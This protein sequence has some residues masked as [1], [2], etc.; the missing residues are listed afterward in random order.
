[1]SDIV[2]IIITFLLFLCSMLI[3]WN[4]YKNEKNTKAIRYKDD[5]SGFEIAEKILENNGLDNLYI[6]ETRS[7]LEERY[8]TRRNVI[9]LLPSRFHGLSMADG[10]NA[11]FLA[12]HAIFDR[13]NLFIHI[14][15]CLL[16]IV[17][18]LIYICYGIIIFASCVRNY[19]YLKLGILGL[20]IIMI[21]H[22]ITVPIE[23][24]IGK[25]IVQNIK[26]LELLDEVYNEEFSKLI[27]SLTYRYIS[28][29][30]S[31]IVSVISI[32]KNQR[33]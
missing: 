22:L 30:V 29:P 33:L 28:L 14:H 6:V 5:L 8:D 9:R 17:N 27:D 19:E 31:L 11:A 32:L 26:D 25:F 23:K 7:F 13:K 3:Y 12:G 15:N 18:I 16:F 4:N 2:I 20:F 10:A 24:N 1:M 21:F